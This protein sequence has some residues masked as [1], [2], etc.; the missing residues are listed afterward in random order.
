[1]NINLAE[2]NIIPD[3]EFSVG[4]SA[5]KTRTGTFEITV[6]SLLV[7]E[8]ITRMGIFG[9][10]PFIPLGSPEGCL[11]GFFCLYN[12]GALP[13]FEIARHRSLEVFNVSAG[14][15]VW[16]SKMR[17]FPKCKDIYMTALD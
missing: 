2:F 11:E 15:K 6:A 13:A 10:A 5:E 3:D 16:P 17:T 4:P 9:S 1:M 8:L 12:T 14:Q 7:T